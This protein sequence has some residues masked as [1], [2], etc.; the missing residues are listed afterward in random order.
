MDRD[1]PTQFQATQFRAKQFSLS[2]WDA[3]GKYH[4]E[5]Q[6]VSKR[7]AITA[8]YGVIARG[9]AKRIIIAND[10]ARALEWTAEEGIVWPPITAPAN[11]YTP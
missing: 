3:S 5:L 9:T 1:R 10:E 2:W 11:T 7:L 8:A 4:K 6:T